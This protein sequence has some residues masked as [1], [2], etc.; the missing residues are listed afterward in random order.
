MPRSTQQLEEIR[1]EK[2]KLI[3]DVA[4]EL[5]A[6][7][8]FHA[9]SIS[10]IAKKAGISK[11]L[12]YNY[13]SSKNEILQHIID[14]GFHEIQELMDPD[15]DGV[16][17]DEEFISVIDKSFGIVGNDL[18]HWK[19]FYSLLLQPSVAD[20]FSEKYARAAEPFFK[21][22]NEFIAQKGNKDPEGDV[23]IISAMIEGA[24]LYS[25]VAPGIFPMEQMKQ[26][27]IE[28]IFRIIETGKA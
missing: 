26:K 20:N 17:T 22:L 13:F 7:H 21:I 9:T 27:V 8:G 15:R 12:A 19:L 6:H 11:G 28:G 23:M 4:L 25:V 14:E 1:K 10:Q 24:L 5:F 16:M 2:K 18:R 3:M